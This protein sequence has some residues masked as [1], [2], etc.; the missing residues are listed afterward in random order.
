[1]SGLVA[2]VAHLFEVRPGIGTPCGDMAIFTTGVAPYPRAISRRMG[3]KVAITTSSRRP[4]KLCASNFNLTV[5][6]VVAA[7]VRVVVGSLIAAAASIG[8]GNFDILSGA[9]IFAHLHSRA[10]RRIVVA[11]PGGAALRHLQRLDPRRGSGR[12]TGGG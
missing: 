3:G 2:V 7:V 6:T 5:P 8:S 11:T 12:H 1:M 4:V 10:A 9:L